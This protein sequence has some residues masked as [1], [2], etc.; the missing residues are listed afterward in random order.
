MID[1]YSPERI[2]D[3]LQI[4]DVIYRWCRSVDRLDREAMLDVFHPDA[5]DSHGPYIGPVDGLVA[6]IFERHKPITF[7]SHFIGNMLIEFAS[8]DVALVESYVRTIQHYPAHAKSQLS[9]LTGGAQGGDDQ[10]TDMFTSSRYLDRMERRNGVWKIAHRTLIQDWKQVVDVHQQALQPHEGWI[11]G[12]RDGHDA[13]E[14]ARRELG[15]AP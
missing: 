15:I 6:W 4:Q 11:I 1:Q 12:R 2:A 3:R 14:E 9:Q 5:F 13:M 10:A 8:P 7:S